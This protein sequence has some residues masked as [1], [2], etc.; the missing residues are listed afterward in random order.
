M[1]NPWIFAQYKDYVATGTYSEPTTQ[2]RFRVAIEHAKFFEKLNSTVFS[3]DPYLF[4]NMR[5]HLGWYVK[6]FPNAS[7]VR[8]KLFQMNSAMEVENLLSTLM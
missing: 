7:E 8:S 1:G 6:S 4:L 3:Q 2:E 5:K